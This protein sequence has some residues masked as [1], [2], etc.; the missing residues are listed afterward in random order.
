MQPE[1]RGFGDGHDILALPRSWPAPDEHDN[2]GDALSRL[3]ELTQGFIAPAEACNTW[4]VMLDGLHALEQD[5][6]QHIYKENS[7]L[8]PR[9]LARE[10]ELQS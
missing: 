1:T 6:H 8:F 7:I 3:R 9:A 5:L 2:A 10:A 4:R